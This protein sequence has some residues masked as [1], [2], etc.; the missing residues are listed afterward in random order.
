MPENED[1]TQEN[2]C[3]SKFLETPRTEE[4]QIQKKIQQN[5]K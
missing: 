5:N 2:K 3:E 4:E 1:K